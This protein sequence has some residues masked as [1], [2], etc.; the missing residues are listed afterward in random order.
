[1]KMDLL[2]EMR[3]GIKIDMTDFPGICDA[4]LTKNR[5]LIMTLLHDPKE[6]IF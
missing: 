4:S 5:A 1:M 6:E 3:R 2:K